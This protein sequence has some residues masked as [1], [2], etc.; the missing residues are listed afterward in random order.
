MAQIG[1]I[2]T[3][4]VWILGHRLVFPADFTVFEGTQTTQNTQQTGFA[5]AIIALQVQPLARL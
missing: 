3:E 1:Q 4:I 2:L 5:N